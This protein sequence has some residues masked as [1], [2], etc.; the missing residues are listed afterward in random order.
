M[1][2]TIISKNNYYK[3]ISMFHMGE[4]ET[5]LKILR[6][7]LEKQNELTIKKCAVGINF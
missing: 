4:G 1:I 2:K 3:H 7:I 5:F 6:L